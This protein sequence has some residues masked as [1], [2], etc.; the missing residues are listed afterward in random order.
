[1]GIL[2]LAQKD[3]KSGLGHFNRSKLLYSFLKKKYSVD[4]FTFQRNKL[5][6][7]TYLFN[8]QN[9]IIKKSVNNLI[10]NKQLIISDEISCPK[11]LIKILIQKNVCSISPNGKLNK[12]SKLIYSRT[13]I[14][15]QNQFSHLVDANIKNFLPGSEIKIIN[16]KKY[17]YGLKKKKLNI[18]ITMG[19]YD[20]KNNTL[21][22][23]KLVYKFKNDINI[24]ILL[25]KKNLVQVVKIKNF[26]KK[27]H[28]SVKLYNMNK[29]PWIIFKN[30]SFILVSG[31]LTAYESAF[32]GLPSINIINDN[33]KKKLTSYLE[34][35]KLTKIFTIYQKNKIKNLIQNYIYKRILLIYEKNRLNKF[36]KKVK[37]DSYKRFEYLLK[38]KKL[39]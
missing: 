4:F 19:G 12:F 37:L 29:N 22:I 20:V 24:H 5:N 25:N 8:L 1:M 36:N 6:K 23:L 31:G 26:I 14:I 38:K 35:K 30:T 39:I 16:N 17:F 32:V 3:F 11:N 28:L 10:K 15:N 18:G 27:K 13:K 34:K 9:K 7:K 2:I 33:N 21:K